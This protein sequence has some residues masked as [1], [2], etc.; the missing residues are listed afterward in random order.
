MRIYVIGIIT[1][2]LVAAVMTVVE[3]LLDKKLSHSENG[4]ENEK[5]YTYHIAMIGDGSAQDS[6]WESIYEGAQ[7]EG[8]QYGMYV[9]DFGAGLSQSYSSMELLHM[10]IAANVDGIIVNPDNGEEISALIDTAVQKGIP[11]ITLLNDNFNSQRMSFVSTNDY[12]LGELYGGR[13]I[14][15]IENRDSLQENQNSSQKNKDTQQTNLDFEQDSTAN[16]RTKITIM[17]GSK[18][19]EAAPNLLYSG[20]RDSVTKS[21]PGRELLWS[22]VTS[23]SGGEFESEETIR[24]IVLD[25]NERPDIIVCLNAMDTISACQCI[26]DYNLVGRISI[27]GYYTSTEILDGIQKGIIDSTIVV[28]TEE[29]GRVSI[30]GFYDYFTKGYVSEYLPVESSLITLDNIN[31]YVRRDDE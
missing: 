19:E 31:D 28:D 26:I 27:I 3:V 17:V 24:N 22:T 1:L 9:Q 14:R 13:L 10:A 12:A 7:E 20:I 25:D 21:L 11:V 15:L 30:R 2:L 8:G 29:M 16:D 18:E 5:K 4:A 23:G 6:F